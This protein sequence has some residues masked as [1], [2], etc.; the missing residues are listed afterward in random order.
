M[1]VKLL[2]SAAGLIALVALVSCGQPEPPASPSPTPA[3]TVP[4]SLDTT[5]TSQPEPTAT[6]FPSPTPTRT[7]QPAATPTPDSNITPS[8]SPLATRLTS[9]EAEER[10]ANG[11]ALGEQARWEEAISEFDEAIRLDPRYAPAYL[12]RGGSYFS[13]GQFERAIQDYDEAVRL[14]PRLAEAYVGRGVAYILLGR[15]SE[16]QQDA[17]RAVELGFDPAVLK[18]VL[19][20]AKEH[21]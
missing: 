1:R 10:N 9:S 4:S 21:R 15:D 5:A 11:V 3:R 13:L 8:P 2:S 6:S 16:A 7:A 17:D 19:D 18:S 14:N 20:E 12:Y